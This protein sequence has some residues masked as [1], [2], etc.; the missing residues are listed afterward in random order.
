MYNTIINLAVLIL[1]KVLIDDSI[2]GTCGL[3]YN[4]ICDGIIRQ[5]FADVKKKV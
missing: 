3:Q 4:R 5:G 2:V 1:I